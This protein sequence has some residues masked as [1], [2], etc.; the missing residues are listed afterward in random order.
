MKLE[1]ENLLDLLNKNNFI[2][3]LDSGTLLGLYRDGKLLDN[4]KDIDISMLNDDKI[5]SFIKKLDNVEIKIRKHEGKIVKIKIFGLSKK[6]VDITIFEDTGKNFYISKLF[7]VNNNHILL[8]NFFIKKLLLS[9][10]NRVKNYN[11]Y[12]LVLFKFIKTG[13]WIIPKKFNN[14]TPVTLS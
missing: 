8:K 14:S 4:D 6:I 2:Y 3:W 11:Y 5:L 7:C 13:Y 12:L 10:L 1:I 9:Y